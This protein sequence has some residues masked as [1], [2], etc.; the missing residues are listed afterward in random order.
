MRK[1][2]RASRD[3]PQQLSLAIVKGDVCGRVDVRVCGSAGHHRSLGGEPAVAHPRQAASPRP[4]SPMVVASGE[5]WW[6]GPAWGSPTAPSQGTSPRSLCPSRSPRDSPPAPPPY[7]AP[8]SQPQ[9]PVEIQSHQS[10]LVLTPELRPSV[11]RVGG[12]WEA[13]L[14]WCVC[15]APG[16]LGKIHGLVGFMLAVTHKPFPVPARRS[17]SSWAAWVSRV[18]RETVS[19]PQK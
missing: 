11:A 14:G 8:R 4:S 6:Q 17:L 5:T 9:C 13:E 10:P 19:H 18:S 7:W 12:H 15:P 3:R 2:A 16:V 1:L